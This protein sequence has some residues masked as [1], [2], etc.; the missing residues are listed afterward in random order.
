M[1]CTGPTIDRNWFSDLPLIV[2]LPEVTV[3]L[4][5]ERGKLYFEKVIKK[6]NHGFILK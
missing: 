1:L 4:E 6:T 3:I 2:K 5:Y